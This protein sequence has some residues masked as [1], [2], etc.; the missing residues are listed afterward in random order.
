[1]ADIGWLERS[2]KKDIDEKFGRCKRIIRRAIWKGR[3][4]GNRRKT[5]RFGRWNK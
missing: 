5:Q 1:M 3:F 2:I 4:N